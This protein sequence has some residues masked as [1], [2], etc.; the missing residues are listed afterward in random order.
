MFGIPA[1]MML[2]LM[3][4]GTPVHMPKSFPAASRRPISLGCAAPTCSA[5]TWRRHSHRIDR[6]DAGQHA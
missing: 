4:A 6:G 3:P 2:S 5:A 1:V